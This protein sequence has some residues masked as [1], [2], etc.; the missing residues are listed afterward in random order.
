MMFQNV[1]LFVYNCCSMPAI[2]AN[3]TV[4]A[5][6]NKIDDQGFLKD[7]FNDSYLSFSV[8]GLSPTIHFFWSVD[9][10]SYPNMP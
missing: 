7:L 8:G 10:S 4:K 9:Y 6:I 5:T 3:T 1:K 2:T